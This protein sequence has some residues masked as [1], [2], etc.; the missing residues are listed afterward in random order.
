MAGLLR[1][2]FGSQGFIIAGLT[3]FA[4][5]A[6]PLLARN[7]VSTGCA[8]S[9]TLGGALTLWQATIATL[10]TVYPILSFLFSLVRPTRTT[11][12]E[13]ALRFT[14]H[15]LSYPPLNARAGIGA[16]GRPRRGW[17]GRSW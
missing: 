14:A 13:G 8:F 17:W 16:K 2:G 6:H 15:A 3:L 7:L 1:G 9:S 11:E 10:V 12:Y 4:S 5:F